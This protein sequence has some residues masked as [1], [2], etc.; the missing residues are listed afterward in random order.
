MT[1]LEEIN[2]LFWSIETPESTVK[3][4]NLVTNLIVQKLASNICD[5]PF[6][7]TNAELKLDNVEI[8]NL[9]WRYRSIFKDRLHPQDMDYGPVW[10][11][12]IEDPN[13]VL[14]IYK[15]IDNAYKE[16]NNGPIHDN[17]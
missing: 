17:K 2:D 16:K 5:H 12:Q 1:L 6:W 14:V 9:R 8:G 7:E 10:I 11:S 3:H 13:D 4:Y 15:L